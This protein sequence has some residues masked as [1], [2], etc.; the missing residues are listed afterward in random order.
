MPSAEEKANELTVYKENMERITKMVVKEMQDLTVQCD[1]E[2]ENAE[3]YK[4][5]AEKVGLTL[6]LNCKLQSE[7][8]T[9][10]ICNV[11][12]NLRSLMRL[13]RH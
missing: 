3:I 12:V 2:R 13:M 8:L 9:G 7:C 11:I 10:F 6:R 1:R 5:E 4:T